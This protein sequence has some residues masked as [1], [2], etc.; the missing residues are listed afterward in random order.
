[1]MAAL[2]AMAC[3]FVVGGRLE[4]KKTDDG[5]KPVFVSGESEIAKLPDAI[6]PKFTALEDFRVDI[7]SSE[8]RA[9][10]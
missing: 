7:S 5:T 8:I 6:R 10:S 2:Q 3:D 9:A 4:Q 1:M